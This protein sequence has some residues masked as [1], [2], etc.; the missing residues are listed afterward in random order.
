MDDGSGVG[1]SPGVREKWEREG[2]NERDGGKWIHKHGFA[3][4]QKFN[5]FF[6]F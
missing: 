5:F 1:A 4:L 6:L 2:E 3:I